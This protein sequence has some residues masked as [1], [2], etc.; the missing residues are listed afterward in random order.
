MVMVMSMAVMTVVV[1]FH[2]TLFFTVAVV[3][4]VTVA[5]IVPMKLLIVHVLRE[6]RFLLGSREWSPTGGC[7]NRLA[8]RFA[9]QE[10]YIAMHLNGDI[11]SGR[12][13]ATSYRAE[14]R[15]ERLTFPTCDGGVVFDVPSYRLIALESGKIGMR[16]I[17]TGP[18]PL[19][20][21]IGAM[22]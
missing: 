22:A 17:S 15:L 7:H 19:D 12:L 3:M 2:M 8:G 6:E 5:V 11:A 13:G 1:V 16:C 4:A 21:G 20:L 9:N 18:S 10:V 14:F